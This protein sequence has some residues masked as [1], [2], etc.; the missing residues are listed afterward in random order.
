MK[1]LQ[2][3]LRKMESA[4]DM[5]SAVM[6]RMGVDIALTSE[7][8]RRMAKGS[9]WTTHRQ[10][11]I[12]I[13]IMNAEIY[14]LRT[15]EGEGFVYVETR[16]YLLFSC[17]FKPS[18][19]TSQLE[20]GLLQIKNILDGSPK[21]AY[22]G[23]DF[24][25]K[26]PTWGGKTLDNRGSLLEEWAAECN[27]CSLNNGSTPTYNRGAYGSYIDVTFVNNRACSLGNPQWRVLEN[28][29]LSDHRYILIAAKGR[30]TIRKR[31]ERTH[32][33]VDKTSLA[34]AFMEGIAT[35]YIETPDQ[36]S[37]VM[38]GAL[39]QV[40]TA[41][42]RK[43]PNAE[44]WSAEIAQLHADCM[45]ARR[46]L[47]RANKRSNGHP[48][49]T[50]IEDLA[51]CRKTLKHKIRDAKEKHWN[52]I[53]R[54]IEENPWGAGFQI[55]MN[56][57]P[58]D[59]PVVPDELQLA[60]V[61]T[62]FPIH[63]TTQYPECAEEEAPLF[64][65]EELRQALT[66]LK[67]KRS[68]GPDLISS[69]NLKT[70]VMTEPK[71]FLRVYN[72]C[73]KAGVFPERWKIAKL[74]LLPKDTPNKFRPICL[75]D[76]VGKLLE[77]L[78]AARL[79]TECEQKNA[80]HD[81]QFGFMKGRSTI[82]AASDV[83]HFL[84]DGMSS[85]GISTIVT[86]DIKNA[87]N[88]ANW[89]IILRALQEK[90]V[91]AYLRKILQSY[92]SN[93]KLIV[94]LSRRR[95]ERQVNS[96]VPQGSI[97]GPLLWNILYDSLLRIK[98]CRNARLVAYADDLAVLATSADRVDME[99]AINGTLKLVTDW[100]TTNKLTIAPDKSEAVTV[101]RQRNPG[102]AR[103]KILGKIIK[104]VNALKYLG[105]W[106][107]AK[108]S[109]DT[110]L[111]ETAAKARVRANALT[112]LMPT[113]GGAVSTKRKVLASVINS[114]SLYG[115]EI[116]GNRLTMAQTTI[117]EQPQA[118]IA[119]R[120]T[121]AYRTTAKEAVLV[122]ADLPPLALEAQRRWD[123]YNATPTARGELLSNWQARWETAT[124]GRWTY[125]LIPQIQKWRLR[126]NGSTDF[127]L[128]QVLTGIGLFDQYLFKIGQAPTDRCGRCLTADTAEHCILQCPDYDDLRGE[129]TWTEGMSLQQTVTTMIADA[130]SFDSIRRTCRK[131]LQ[132]RR[133]DRTPTQEF[134]NARARGVSR[135]Q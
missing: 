94:N 41:E 71:V 109:F 9:K 18:P 133:E 102:E 124:T 75:L 48:E 116:W 99:N 83:V 2:I 6:K 43:K 131:I 135:R 51:R 77:G 88:S 33:E 4:H 107:D 82:D 115:A 129:I 67:P 22:V 57:L 59:P 32:K 19:D 8:N 62:L 30:N 111:K 106:I 121:S 1:I 34:K 108:L 86:V 17:Y 64:S 110:H 11:S 79:K 38:T 128:T 50:L 12:G 26:S 80:I 20:A 132:R 58:H 122:L 24:N 70:M 53:C 130:A 112:R 15:G 103:I 72:E 60:A 3:N 78:L 66:K 113:H 93:R 105:I 123:N 39:R 98:V 40:Q 25:A 13:K 120:I 52:E 44:W 69:I 100:M 16:N 27:L 14:P 84:R 7:I 42:R 23:G 45:T 10:Q 54:Q 114:V 46:A 36:L 37:E 97:L 119:R 89:T 104:P 87:F 125:E 68:T 76:S 65:E 28:E 118:L 117:L 73:L 96:G 90:G 101:T 49:T 61:E 127:Y 91:S 55:V 63:E 56:N 21:E 31:T 5:L 126:Q 35:R 92:L 74:L 47:A 85:G 81:H 95:H 134:G 29:S